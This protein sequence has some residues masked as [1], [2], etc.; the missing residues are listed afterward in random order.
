MIFK[1]LHAKL[2]AIYFIIVLLFVGCLGGTLTISYR[3]NLTMMREENVI[4]CAKQIAQM[5]ADGSLSIVDIENGQTI[6]VLMTTAKDFDATIQIVNT[7]SK[8][9]FYNMS[10]EKMTVYE[11]DQLT[12][13]L[14][15][16]NRSSGNRRPC[17][18]YSALH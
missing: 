3:K 9:L 14:R 2:I 8:R 15:A 7:T 17:S 12:G 18:L 1:S 5:Y 10:E 11:K 6:P 16:F 13:N 4:D